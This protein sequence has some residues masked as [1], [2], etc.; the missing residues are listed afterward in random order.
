MKFRLTT[1]T[2]QKKLHHMTPNRM[3][4]EGNECI[5]KLKKKKKKKDR[6]QTSSFVKIGNECVCYMMDT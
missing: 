5:T 1:K 6:E 4:F 3:L 2:P